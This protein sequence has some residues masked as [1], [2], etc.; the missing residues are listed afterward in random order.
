[1]YSVLFLYLSEDSNS[2]QNFPSAFLTT[3]KLAEKQKGLQRHL[4]V[5]SMTSDTLNVST[6]DT[7]RWWNSSL[8]N[9]CSRKVGDESSRYEILNPMLE[10]SHR[11]D[12]TWGNISLKCSNESDTCNVVHWAALW[13]YSYDILEQNKKWEKPNRNLLRIK[14][15]YG[16]MP[17]SRT[18]SE[19]F[20]RKISSRLL[21]SIRCYLIIL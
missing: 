9:T 8:I 10:I 6:G 1:M 2:H 14:L 7:F 4:K 13:I 16:Y 19:N 15:T 21:E 5:Q 3:A 18:T 12:Y 11:I 20:Y 17:G